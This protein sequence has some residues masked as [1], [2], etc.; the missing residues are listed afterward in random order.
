MNQKI[1]ILLVEDDDRIRSFMETI[2][3]SNGYN[4][5]ETTN[6]RTALSMAASHNPDLMLL[7]LG[8]PDM[9][10]QQLIKSIREWSRMPIVVVSARGHEQDKVTA[11]DNGADDYVTKPFGMN[12]LLARIRAALRNS[13]LLASGAASASTIFQTRG[14]IV[15]TDKR[16]VKIDGTLVH[17]TQIEYKIVALLARNAGRVL[18]YDVILRE[19]WGPYASC[20]TQLLRVNM[21]NIR[22]KIE[23]DPGMPEYITTEIGVGYRLSAE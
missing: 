2:L 20:D 3:T 21:A 14:L 5:L 12:E 23:K 6:A 1:N 13:V 8:L 4:V 7:D 10:G 17:L 9:D 18:T 11:L 22:R 15:D 16:L 19:V